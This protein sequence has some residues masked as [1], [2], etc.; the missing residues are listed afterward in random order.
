MMLSQSE[1]KDEAWEFMKWWTSEEV[2]VRFGRDVEALWGPQARW[3]TANLKAFKRLPWKREDLEIIQKQWPW[4]TEPP[5]V[6]G[7]YFTDR[8]IRNA[9]TRV[10]MLGMNPRESL[11]IAVEDINRELVIKQEEYRVGQ[12]R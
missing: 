1:Q 10:L 6:A 5:V 7:G 2:Q 12:S 8:H 3:P 9:F 4:Y 11:E